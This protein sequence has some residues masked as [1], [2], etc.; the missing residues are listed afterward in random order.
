MGLKLKA[1]FYM[2]HVKIASKDAKMQN[3]NHYNAKNS[4]ISP[5]KKKQKSKKIRASTN[6]HYY[7]FHQ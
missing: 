5:N 3:E 7:K 4:A 6:L 2:K 1:I